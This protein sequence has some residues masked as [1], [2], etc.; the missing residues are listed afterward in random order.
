MAEGVLS[1][2]FVILAMLLFVYR[3]IDALRRRRIPRALLNVALVEAM[4]ALLVTL[5]PV[6]YLLDPH[7]Y[8]F[9]RIDPKFGVLAVLQDDLLPL[10]AGLTT[11]ALVTLLLAGAASE[12]KSG[13]Q[14]LAKVRSRRV[15]PGQRD[16]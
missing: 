6:R 12:V 9:V 11:L 16:R 4:A 2:A 7:P 5:T 10:G 13:Q 8:S 3:A 1:L 14:L 15:R